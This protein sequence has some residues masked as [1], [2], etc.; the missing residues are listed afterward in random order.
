MAVEM[1]GVPPTKPQVP[2]GAGIV[3]SDSHLAPLFAGIRPSDIVAAQ[4]LGAFAATEGL[5]K[6]D[7][8]DRFEVESA[9]TKPGCVRS[10]AIAV[11]FNCALREDCK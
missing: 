4:L 7:A 1:I 11:Y 6:H 9:G 2:P 8:G 5:L 3:A 10:E